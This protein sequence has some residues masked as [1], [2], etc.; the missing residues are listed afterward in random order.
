MTACHSGTCE[1]AQRTAHASTV[2][3]TRIDE[4]C[5]L[6]RRASASWSAACASATC[7]GD[8]VRRGEVDS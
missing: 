4:G 3:S 2:K 6:R 8:E 1:N 7:Q 5:M